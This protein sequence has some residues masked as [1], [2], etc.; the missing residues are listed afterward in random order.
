MD[1]TSRGQTEVKR[2]FVSRKPESRSPTRQ[3]ASSSVT[4]HFSARGQIRAVK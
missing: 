3:C 2:L 1:M 4:F